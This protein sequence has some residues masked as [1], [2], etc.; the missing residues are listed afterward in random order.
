[1]KFRR[2]KSVSA[3]TPKGFPRLTQLGAL[4]TSASRNTYSCDEINDLANVWDAF[5]V[6]LHTFGEFGTLLRKKAE[7]IRSGAGWH[8]ER[9]QSGDERDRIEF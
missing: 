7:A 2:K 4:G 6:N 8:R 5:W 3:S 1:M 9:S